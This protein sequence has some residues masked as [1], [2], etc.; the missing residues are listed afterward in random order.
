MGV[1]SA[2][3][4]SAGYE[5]VTRE[6]L[7]D[8]LEAAIAMGRTLPS[9]WYTDPEILRLEQQHVFRHGWL[10]AGHAG[11]LAEPGDH[12]VAHA[13]NI[14]VIVVRGKEGELRGFVNL[15]RHR[16]H[17]MVLPHRPPGPR[18]TTIQCPYHGWTYNLD[19]TLRGAPRSDREHGFDKSQW[20]LVPVKVD[21]WGPLVFINAD[22]DASPLAE[23]LG[24][25]PAV[26]RERGLDFDAFTEHGRLD[27]EFATNWKV[28]LDNNF[29]CYHCPVAHPG[30]SALYDT[31]P[32]AYE[33]Q[34]FEYSATQLSPHKPDKPDHMNW[35]DFRFYYLWPTTFIVDHS[36]VFNVLTIRP[37]TP[38]RS[39]MTF[40]LYG[41]SGVEPEAIDEY[42]RFYDGVFKQDADLIES[43][44]RGHEAQAVPV[45]PLFLNS[46][47]L[48]QLEQRRLSAAFDAGK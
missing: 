30:F 42:G 18:R 12:V 10:Y 24:G 36:I 20:S 35:G 17:E 23:Q 26:A 48:I 38:G 25:M 31:D 34:T 19:G 21:T 27:Y 45:G 15:C 43:V 8:E 4:E 22:L 41:R 40:E 32:D 3:R 16:L 7:L 44:Q 6:R 2:G 9:W 13:G 11:R 29:E 5:P 46:E 47:H 14:P 28:V 37:L 39:A 1:I 33:I